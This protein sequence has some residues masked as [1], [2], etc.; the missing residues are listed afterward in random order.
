[1]ESQNDRTT[2]EGPRPADQP[3]PAEQPPTPKKRFRIEKLEERIAPKKG[4]TTA[5]GGFSVPYSY[6]SVY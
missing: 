4:T 1:M 2:S 3:R 6:V 5:S